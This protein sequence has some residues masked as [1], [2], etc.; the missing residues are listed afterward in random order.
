MTAAIYIR[1]SREDK[2]KPAHRLTV[3]RQQLPDYAMAQGWTP[4]VYDDGHA[5][6]ARGKTEDLEERNRLEADIKAG[7]INIILTIELSRLSRDD[8]MQD[9]TAWLHL[10]SQ[11]NVKLATM[12]RTL[13]P[14]QHSD[15]MLLLMEGGF[16]SVEMKV[17]QGRMAEGRK[18]AIRSGKYI[19]GN[20]P[21]PYVKNSAT[22]AIEIDPDQRTQVDAILTM[23]E[24]MSVHRIV[25]QTGLPQIKI[26]RM[27]S[28]DRL[29]FYL[30]KIL[31]PD[32]GEEIDGQWPPL[33]DA[34]RATTIRQAR[35]TR[36]P[37]GKNRE[38]GGLL[39]NLDGL[40]Q[41]G[42]CGRTAK[43]WRNS[44]IKNDGTR[45]NYYGCSHSCQKSRLVQQKIIDDK[46]ITNLLGTL[47]KTDHLAEAWTKNNTAGD[48]PGQLAAIDSEETDLL[49]KKQRLIQAITEG[50]IS[51]ADA[52]NTRQQI[53]NNLSALQLQRRKI[54]AS[55]QP[56]PD[57]HDLQKRAAKWP[58]MTEKEQRDFL[59]IN[60]A[61]IRIY[62]NYALVS[63]R[64]PRTLD[65]NQ[66]ARVHLPEPYKPS[67]RKPRATNRNTAK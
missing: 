51:F 57:W 17:L 2:N 46:V 47:K 27:I 26:R 5:S 1:K 67:T 21:T 40:L 6:A 48:I 10:C 18:Q 50:V 13:D 4:I 32:S 12:S 44:R 9:Y 16:S 38:A 62:Y 55:R 35:R 29:L 39:S 36:K 3:Q 34:D 56:E 15:W 28:D 7:K 25:Q 33:I 37:Y 52:K 45:N 24:T 43:A 63:Y 42:Y 49:G 54:Q 64:Y 20:P 14:A 22:G 31:D 53:E 58:L 23:A 59:Q 61:E 19:W 30:G 11:H 8:S 66:T 41:C 65:G 60:L